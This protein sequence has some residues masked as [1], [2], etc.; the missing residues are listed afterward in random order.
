M[1]ETKLHIVF[2]DDDLDDQ[3]L[4]MQAIKAVEHDIRLSFFDSSD[5][6]LQQL[7]NVL[8]QAGPLLVLLDLN[9]PPQG[10]MSVLRQLTRLQPETPVVVYSTS[11]ADSDIRAAYR[12]GAKSFL[13]KPGTYSEAVSMMGVLC[14][15]WI[16]VVS[17][18]GDDG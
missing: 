3:Y 14:D 6:F 16:N 12:A 8:A 13:V 4:L 9:L 1:Q 15:Y 17:L 2:V 18:R 5:G 11:S 10:G 7:D